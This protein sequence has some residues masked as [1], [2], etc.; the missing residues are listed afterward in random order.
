M[1]SELQPPAPANTRDPAPVHPADPWLSLIVAGVI[2]LLFPHVRKLLLWV[3]DPES[4]AQQYS[5]SDPAGR[6]IR[7]P[8]SAFFLEDVG[9]AVFAG[10]LLVEGVLL[11]WLGPR[12]R[13]AAGWVLAF[14]AA[15][16]LLVMALT[17]GPIGFRLLPTVALIAC[18]YSAVRNL[19]GGAK[20]TTVPS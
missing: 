16:N 18:S 10:C 13:T 2:L 1:S 17:W 12:G 15:V 4:F 9:V 7:Y 5:Y 14:G 8:D 19:A 11:L 6:P 20:R 3:R